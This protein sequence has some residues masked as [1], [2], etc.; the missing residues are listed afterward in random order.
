VIRS[1]DC[2]D[3]G[4]PDG[5]DDHNDGGNDNGW[6]LTNAKW[7]NVLCMHTHTRT[8]TQRSR[9]KGQYSGRS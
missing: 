1:D 8:Y 5:D 3:S 2:G 4:N 6:S 9:K 7:Q